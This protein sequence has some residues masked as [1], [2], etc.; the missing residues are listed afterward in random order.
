M[1]AH[2]PADS[3]AVNLVYSLGPILEGIVEPGV[4]APYT[5]RNQV[6]DPVSRLFFA[7]LKHE[8]RSQRC[9]HIRQSAD[10]ARHAALLAHELDKSDD[11]LGFPPQ[12]LERVLHH[13]F[14][15]K[16][17]CALETAQ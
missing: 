3:V 4:V 12:C 6:I 14:E 10:I 16:E 5:L 7:L 17:C 15:L 8:P 2:T 9:N 13:V 11:T 1:L